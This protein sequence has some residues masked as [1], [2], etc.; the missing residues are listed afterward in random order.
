MKV[1][2]KRV[3]LGAETAFKGYEPYEHGAVHEKA[4]KMGAHCTSYVLFIL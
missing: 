3:K 4:K 1:E 2:I